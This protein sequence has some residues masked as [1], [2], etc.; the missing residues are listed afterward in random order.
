M[1][2]K[3]YNSPVLTILLMGQMD[4]LTGSDEWWDVTEDD[5]G[6]WEE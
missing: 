1:K 4:V 2:L 3:D 6:L 5:I